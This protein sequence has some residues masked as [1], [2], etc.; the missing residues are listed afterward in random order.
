[1]NYFFPWSSLEMWDGRTRTRFD[2]R[3]IREAVDGAHGATA[4][5]LNFR[6]IFANTDCRQRNVKLLAVSSYQCGPLIVHLYYLPMLSA[7]CFQATKS[8]PLVVS[9]KKFYHTS[10]LHIDNVCE[11]I[12]LFFFFLKFLSQL[13]CLS[14]FCPLCL[15]GWTQESCPATSHKVP[16]PSMLEAQYTWKRW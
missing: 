2:R 8:N 9:P 10:L 4:T 13:H 16:I 3:D 15:L 14:E 11:Y 7:Y 6:T 1:M 5:L 12:F